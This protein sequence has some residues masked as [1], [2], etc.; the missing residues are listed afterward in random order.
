[1]IYSKE[2]LLEKLKELTNRLERHPTKE[3]IDKS[4]ITPHS[5]SYYKYFKT[6][7]D[8]FKELNL[9]LKSKCKVCN[10][11]FANNQ[12]LAVHLTQKEDINHINYYKKLKDLKTKKI[13]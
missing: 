5:F 10:K 6:L 8:A 3:E 4:R 11:E 1:M 12:S 9:N 7:N 2:E 13:K